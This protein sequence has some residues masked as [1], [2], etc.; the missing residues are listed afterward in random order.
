MRRLRA[1]AR[2]GLWVLR[3]ILRPLVLFALVFVVGGVVEHLYGPHQ[4]WPQAFFVS[5]TLMFGEH[6]EG[7]PENPLAQLMHYGQ[8]LLGVILVSDG[9][10]RLGV[11]LLNK[12]ANARI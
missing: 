10:V 9:V 3:S 6:L 4:D 11:N 2:Y 5:Y 1:E 7:T 12:D 8:P